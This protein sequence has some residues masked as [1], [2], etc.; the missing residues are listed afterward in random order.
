MHALGDEVST[1]V[2]YLRCEVA[3]AVEI[4]FRDLRYVCLKDSEVI[5]VHS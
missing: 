1:S 2:G 5:A 3:Q 4:T